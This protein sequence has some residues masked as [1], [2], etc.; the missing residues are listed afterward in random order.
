MKPT[1]R[2]LQGSPAPYSITMD[3]EAAR[4]Y[5]IDGAAFGNNVRFHTLA[6]YEAHF[7]TTQYIHQKVDWWGRPA[8]NAETVSPVAFLP[9]GFEVEAN[10][11]CKVRDKRPTAPLNLPS[12]TTKRYTSL[13][14]SR[15]RKPRV[16]MPNDPNSEAFLVEV[17]KQAKF[18]QTMKLSR[19]K[20]GAMGSVCVTIHLREGR[21]V[22]EVHNPRFVDVIWKDRRTW[23]PQAILVWQKY[24]VEEP[25]HDSKGVVTGMEIVSYLYRRIITEMDDTIYVPVKV[26]ESQTWEADPALTVQHNLGFFPGVWIQNHPNDES[27]DGAPDCD[28]AWQMFDTMDR[29]NSQSNKAL[30]H[31]QDPTL[32]IGYDPKEIDA[33]GPTTQG[34]VKTGS[35]A[36]LNVG[37]SGHANFL[38]MSAQGVTGSREFVGGLK[39][40]TSNVTGM[41]FPSAEKMS[42]AAQ[43]ARAMEFLFE[44]TLE[45]ADDLREQFG[46]AVRDLAA[47]TLDIGRSFQES[48][49][50]DGPT[51][52]PVKFELDLPDKLVPKVDAEGA[53]LR[54]PSGEEI[55]EAVPHSVGP[56]GPIEIKWGDFF[57]PTDSDNQAKITNA[58]AANA[59]GALDVETMVS[60]IAPIF[61]VEDI[62]AMIRNVKAEAEERDARL[63]A[64]A[65]LDP[66]GGFGGGGPTTP[67]P[68]GENAG[69]VNPPAAGQG[70]KP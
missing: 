13:L 45:V 27:P 62:Q 41:Q 20:A 70:G 31:N 6:R 33:G 8:D 54:T 25:T 56:G 60:E 23:T 30:L 18:N 63:M 37:K 28:G 69:E 3:P 65:G 40:D 14:F 47:L 42:G 61:G 10:K 9:P 4:K 36:V 59:G 48:K 46:P 29:L 17:F 22:F 43:S 5:L 34:Q 32:E 55:V 24:E 11:E 67:N 19:N 50:V 35:D 12:A 57:P 66:F 51:G 68:S 1:T 15:D 49:L 21:F 52:R 16:S 58:I 39:E 44:P 7:D 2:T 26:D 64:G 53:Q 38:E